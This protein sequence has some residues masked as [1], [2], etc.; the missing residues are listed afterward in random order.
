MAV[1]SALRR[2][3]RIRD[4]EE[5]QSQIALGSA[6]GKLR[7]LNNA[8]TASL[9]RGRQGRELIAASVTSGENVDRQAGLIESQAAERQTLMLEPRIAASEEQTALLRQEVLEKR[10]ECRQAETLIEET[11]TRVAI[12][13]SRRDQRGLDDWFGSRKFREHAE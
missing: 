9:G 2:L 5:E 1:T 4:L 3:L 11:E 10:V 6:L 8:R 7:D 13:A 12:E